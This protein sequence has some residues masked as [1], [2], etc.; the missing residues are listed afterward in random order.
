MDSAGTFILVAEYQNSLIRKII[1]S[2]ALVST[3][4]GGAAAGHTDGV[5][6]AATFNNPVGVAMDPGGTVAVVGEQTNNIIRKIIIAT[7]VV[8]TM[9]GTCCTAGHADGVGSAASFSSPHG[10]AIDAAVTF[11][12][13][14]DMTNGMIRRI[15]LGTGAVTTVAG[16][17][18]TLGHVDG[19]GTAA[20]F[21]NPHG[22]GMDAAGTFVLVVSGAASGGL[23]R[24]LTDSDP[25]PAG[26]PEQYHPPSCPE[27][28]DS[29]DVRGHRHSRLCGRE[30]H[31][32]DI[33]Q[34]AR[35]CV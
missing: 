19:V 11:T 27:L 10:L 20:T 12:I 28:E 18:A 13:L 34:P 1:V 17:S 16:N 32:R 22:L 33:Q 25:G 35:R 4:A 24:A 9:A 21:N 7:A 29:H 14:C 31:R 6:T 26:R 30:R 3:L 2:S 8:T 15:D 23:L 5:G